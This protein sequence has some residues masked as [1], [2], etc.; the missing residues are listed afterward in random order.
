MSDKIHLELISI[1]GK[2]EY[3]DVDSVYV[4]IPY[5]G[6][7]GILPNRQSI[8]AMLHIGY[9]YYTIGDEKVVFAISGGVLNFRD[10]RC[11]ILAD[12]WEKQD[13]LDLERITRAKERAEGILE[14]IDNKNSIEYQNATFSLKKAVNRLKLLKW[15]YRNEKFYLYL[16]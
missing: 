2:E 12:T 4:D 10:N 16:S 1:D 3:V 8:V 6:V 11:V 13:E 15:G 14:K 9:F 5:S 7:L